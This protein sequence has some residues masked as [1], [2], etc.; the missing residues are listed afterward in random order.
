MILFFQLIFL[1]VLVVALTLYNSGVIGYPS[2]NLQCLSL[3]LLLVALFLVFFFYLNF[4]LTGSV[5]ASRDKLK[6]KSIYKI[7]LL[8]LLSRIVQGTA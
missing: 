4:K 1:S 3:N 2:V 6:L 5:Y 8:L 7:L